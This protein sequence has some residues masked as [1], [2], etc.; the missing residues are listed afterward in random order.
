M[1]VFCAHRLKSLTVELSCHLGIEALGDRFTL[2]AKQQVIDAKDAFQGGVAMGE[3]CSDLNS[4]MADAKDDEHALATT[5]SKVALLESGCADHK[6]MNTDADE[7]DVFSS[8]TRDVKDVL[9][10]DV[11]STTGKFTHKVQNRNRR[12][13]LTCCAPDGSPLQ[14]LHRLPIRDADIY[15]YFLI[16]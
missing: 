12:L 7:K 16:V 11:V 8:M 13:T 4:S 14:G 2:D 1:S 5:G 6:G 15:M 9:E 3:T 10:D